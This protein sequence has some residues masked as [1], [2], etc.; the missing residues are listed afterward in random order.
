MFIGS[1]SIFKFKFSV[2]AFRYSFTEYSGS[3]S[4]I[5]MSGLLGLIYDPPI[6][7]GFIVVWSVSTVFGVCVKF[8]S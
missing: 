7:Y 1:G 8:L 6:R 5:I 3:V 4:V 2:T